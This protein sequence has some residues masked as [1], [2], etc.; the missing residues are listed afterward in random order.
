MKLNK[1]Y[2]LFF[3]LA[4]FLIS[5]RDKNQSIDIEINEINREELTYTISNNT[6]INYYIP[7]SPKN[8]VLINSEIFPKENGIYLLIK[9][10]EGKVFYTHSKDYPNRTELLKDSLLK[11]SSPFFENKTDSWIYYFRRHF[12]NNLILPKKE[13]KVFKVNLKN[14]LNLTQGK[15]FYAKMTYVIDSSEYQKFI[16]SEI[17]EKLKFNNYKIYIGKITSKKY[18]LSH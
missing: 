2:I 14:T 9:D 17:T 12:V 3:F 7:I 16:P 4:L 18:S 11:K 5:C 1:T 10:K 15:Q 6:D 13:K 8:I